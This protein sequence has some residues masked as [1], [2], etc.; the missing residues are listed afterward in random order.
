MSGE[1]LCLLYIDLF[2]LLMRYDVKLHVFTLYLPGGK[3]FSFLVQMG[4]IP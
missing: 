3:G 4:K 2:R 1:I